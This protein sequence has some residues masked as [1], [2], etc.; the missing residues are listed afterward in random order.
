MYNIEKQQKIDR[1][2]ALLVMQLQHI[3]NRKPPTTW[4]RPQR[5]TN[6][7]EE[8]R[9]RQYREIEKNNAV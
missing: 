6:P 2:N 3:M 9:E 1:E 5:K 7:Y 8:V 4:Q